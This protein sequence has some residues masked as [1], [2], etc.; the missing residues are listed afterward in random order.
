[1]SIDIVPD[2]S[3]ETFIRSLKRFCARQGLPRLFVSD[4]GKTFKA[5]SRVIATIVADEAVQQ[6]VSQIRVKWHF[7]LAEAPWW[8]EIF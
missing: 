4:N 7:N 8:G 3:T 5:A 2:M 6:F 1:M